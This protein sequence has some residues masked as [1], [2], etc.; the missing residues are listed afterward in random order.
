[1]NE[2][3][4]KDLLKK[5]LSGWNRVRENPVADVAL[6]FTPAGVAADVQDA[7][8]AVKARDALGL[9]L[10]GA[11]FVPFAGDV[12]KGAG[13]AVREAASKLPMSKA[14]RMERARELGFD[15]DKPMYHGSPDWRTID[16]AGAFEARARPIYLTSN[17]RVARGY[18]EGYTSDYQNAVEGI[19]NFYVNPGRTLSVPFSA[20]WWDQLPAD[21][22]RKALEESEVAQ[23]DEIIEDLARK[24][25]S[26]ELSTG[27]LANIARSLG[28]DSFE[29]MNIIDPKTAVDYREALRNVSTVRGVFDPARLRYTTAAF[30]PARRESANLLAGTAGAMLGGSALARALREENK[31]EER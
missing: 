23:F 1:M 24:R 31:R 2:E 21:K 27:D 13:K 30:D 26:S 14:A 11:G 22:V 20:N 16:E 19:R 9:M 12:V 29:A 25:G 17:K 8:R 18:S 6:G 28:Y 5:L 3:D 7:A 4:P 10:A 15:V